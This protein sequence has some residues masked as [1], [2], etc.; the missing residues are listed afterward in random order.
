MIIQKVFS[1][2]YDEERYYSVLMSEEE[3]ALF[4]D[5]TSPLGKLTKNVGSK[6]NP[7]SNSDRMRSRQ[8]ELLNKKLS[9]NPGIFGK[10]G[11]WTGNNKLAT[12][13]I[14]LTAAAGL[15]YGAY[16]LAKED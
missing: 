12:A 10:A 3:L 4:T 13:G 9:A 1:N 7:M 15:G 5:F 2:S 11:Q 16:R 14:G 8:T 6:W